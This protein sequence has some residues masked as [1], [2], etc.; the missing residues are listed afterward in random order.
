MRSDYN[1]LLPECTLNDCSC[2]NESRRDSAAEMTAAPCVLEAVILAES[3]KIGMA[4]SRLACKCGIIGAVRIGVF[5]QNAN[6]RARRVTVVNSALKN[7]S[8]LF[9][10]SCG[11][12]SARSAK[13]HFRLYIIRV[14][15]NS[16]GN[17]VYHRSDCASVALAEK[18]NGQDISECVLHDSESTSLHLAT[19]SSTVIFSSL[20][21]PILSTVI[22]VIVSPPAFLS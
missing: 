22:T 20:N 1:T 11:N 15:F 17:S 16:G 12:L 14:D 21:V 2:G 18:R 19:I 10:S 7:K 13:R 3:R 5:Y 6:R 8:V 4:G 9:A